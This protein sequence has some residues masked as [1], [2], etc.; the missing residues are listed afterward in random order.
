[1]VTSTLFLGSFSQQV[2]ATQPAGV[3]AWEKMKPESEAY[4]VMKQKC[5]QDAGERIFAQRDNVKGIYHESKEAKTLA[6]ITGS[7]KS[8]GITYTNPPYMYLGLGLDFVE[9]S[10]DL[11]TMRSF[12]S[13]KILPDQPY[14][15]F[16]TSSYK[17]EPV[18]VRTAPIRV[19]Y[20]RTT[21]DSE[22]AVGIHGRL[23]EIF[24]DS[25][26]TLLAQ[27]RDYIYV[28]GGNGPHGGLVC[29]APQNGERL[30][31]TFLQKVINAEPAAGR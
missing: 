12:G 2:F 31:T 18:K 7:T 11:P 25:T 26:G 14:R 15:R 19:S 20:K 28:I 23:I 1:M 29:P 22:D 3:N 4:K 17:T 8:Y 24:D 5:E 16:A 13:V 10:Q 6:Y 30:M 9:Y 27:R 21:T